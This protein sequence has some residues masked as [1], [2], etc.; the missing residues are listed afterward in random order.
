MKSLEPNSEESLIGYLRRVAHANA[1]AHISD[2][3][4]YLGASY[5]RPMIENLGELTH[6]LGISVSSLEEISPHHSPTRPANQWHFQHSRIDPYCPECLKSDATWRQDWRHCF[7]TSCAEHQILLI[8]E[9]PRCSTST[10]PNVGGYLRCD[11]AFEFATTH[12][13]PA[14]PF[15][16]W[17]GHGIS[18]GSVA[19]GD[20]SSYGPWSEDF[21]A[22]FS[23]FLQFVSS[24]S[25]S[26]R[27]EKPG[28]SPLPK[29]L[30]EARVFLGATEPL[31]LDWPNGFNAHVRNRINSG[32]PSANSAPARLGKWYQRLMQFRGEAYQPF[33]DQLALIIGEEFDGTYT[34]QP[35]GD[36]A[37]ISATEAAKML[38]VRS[39]RVVAAVA[40]GKLQGRLAKTGLGHT[41]TTVLRAD[42]EVAKQN[43]DTFVTAKLAMGFLGVGKRQFEL[44]KD[45][46]LV[47]EEMTADLPVF[48]PGR[49]NQSQIEALSKT[50][51]EAAQV[52][53]DGETIPFREINLRKTTDRSALISFYKDVASRKIRPVIAPMNASLGEFQFAK[54]DIERS[55]QPG[56]EN[57]QWTAHQVAQFA[58]W[59]HEVVTHWCK[60]GLLKS[61]AKPHGS[62]RK[63]MISPADLVSFQKKYVVLADLAAE[64]GTT[65]P[66]LLRKLKGQNIEVVGA[67][68]VGATSR[69]ALLEI[70][71]I[72]RI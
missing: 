4:S 14:G 53:T 67:K 47:R 11:C 70:S 44:L 3:Y 23:S 72:G 35:V 41:H 32:D 28:K 10:S 15:E 34:G 46:G 31:F 30:A 26:L 9:C 56:V 12:Q 57:I 16:N 36:R 17:I 61:T 63:Y 39:E 58:G 1:Y 24:S 48:A 60:L 29:T 37:W 20:V 59:K 19:N 64:H 51:R 40:A 21:P 45:A 7:V 5:G 50:I 71:N 49:F 55:L 69:G 54:A 27:T 2:L 13:T 18:G 65:S 6:T 62:E 66:A 52:Q 42:V 68:K 33:H 22:D 25:L 43:K 38:A 8:D